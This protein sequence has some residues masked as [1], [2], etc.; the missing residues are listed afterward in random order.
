M[1]RDSRRFS[2]SEF[3]LG[4]FHDIQHGIDTGDASPVKQRIR[5]NPVCFRGRKR[6]TLK[7]MLEAGVIPESRV[8]FSTS[9]DQKKRWI[10]VLITEP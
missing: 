5:L 8:G 3:D 4:T 10:S 1:N 7:R 6:P 2:K 9:I